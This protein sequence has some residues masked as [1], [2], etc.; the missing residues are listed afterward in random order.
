MTELSMA[1]QMDE[2]SF[3]PQQPAK[4]AQGSTSQ[5]RDRVADE[6][7]PPV[8]NSQQAYSPPPAMYATQGPS[9][10]HERRAAPDSFWDR[11]AY[12]RWDVVKLFVLALIV[13]LALS[14]DKLLTFYLEG[15]VA[16]SFLSATNEF[17]ARLS[18]PVAILLIIWIIKASA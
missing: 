6:Q 11:L 2:P 18:Y 9:P 15:Y 16:K 10:N 1:Y 17:L 7:Q 8:N 4:S 13:V 3:M 5:Y 12:K 14:I